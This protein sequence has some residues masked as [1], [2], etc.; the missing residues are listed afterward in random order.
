MSALAHSGRGRDFSFGSRAGNR[1][2]PIHCASKNGVRRRQF[3]GLSKNRFGKPRR[4]PLNALFS[5]FDLASPGATSQAAIGAF[6]GTDA[7]VKGCLLAVPAVWATLA[8]GR[9]LPSRTPR[10]QRQVLRRSSAG[11]LRRRPGRD[12]AQAHG[13]WV[14]VPCATVCREVG[15]LTSPATRVSRNRRLH[16]PRIAGQLGHVIGKVHW[17]PLNLGVWQIQRMVE[18]DVPRSL[19]LGPLCQPHEPRG[20]G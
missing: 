17:G 4:W 12:R 16:T 2:E 13:D 11:V 5:T 9:A 18:H 3:I 6:L 8:P 1:G 14:M 7:E 10:R 19:Q 20:L 15:S